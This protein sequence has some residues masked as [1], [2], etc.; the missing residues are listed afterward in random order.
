[1]WVKVGD[2]LSFFWRVGS[3]KGTFVQAALN[4]HPPI[5]RFGAASTSLASEKP[6]EAKF[7]KFNKVPQLGPALPPFQ[8]LT[9]GIYSGTVPYRYTISS[10]PAIISGK[11]SIIRFVHFK[12]A[13]R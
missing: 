4:K 5:E 7:D 6:P 1:M 13:L 10:H 9:I 11:R 2:R 8:I 12:C 3:A